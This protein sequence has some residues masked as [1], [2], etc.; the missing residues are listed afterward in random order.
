[1]AEYENFLRGLDQIGNGWV[2]VQK[3][4]APPRAV[5]QTR[6]NAKEPW[7]AYGDRGQPR[8]ANEVSTASMRRS[9]PYPLPGKTSNSATSTVP[10]DQ[11]HLVEKGACD[12]F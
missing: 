1:M 8:S 7:E 4:L 3:L 9:F 12:E 6:A 5:N 11:V 2:L 10:G